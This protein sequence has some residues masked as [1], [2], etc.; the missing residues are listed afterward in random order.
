ML[1]AAGKVRQQ[2][3]DDEL[4]RAA[5]DDHEPRVGELLATS[6]HASPRPSMFLYGSS[7][8]TK[9]TVGRS[10]SGAGGR[11]VNAERS[12]NAVNTA[13]GS[14]PRTSSISFDV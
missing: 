6:R 9:T 12:L 11:S 13:L 4:L 5:A 2:P 3:L 7:E 10:G 1:D 14:T 8:P